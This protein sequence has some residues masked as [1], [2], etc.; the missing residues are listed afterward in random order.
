MNIPH[1]LEPLVTEF[2]SRLSKDFGDPNIMTGDDGSCGLYWHRLNDERELVFELYVDFR[3]CGTKVKLYTFDRYRI[4][5]GEVYL[6]IPAVIPMIQAL[7]PD[8]RWDTDLTEVQVMSIEQA[9]HKVETE[10]RRQIL[11]NGVVAIPTTD[12]GRVGADPDAFSYSLDAPDP[13]EDE[14]K[15][16][17]KFGFPQDRR[18]FQNKLQARFKMKGRKR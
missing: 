5:T 2:L 15:N 9:R 16:A 6:E 4:W 11:D 7:Y 3:A 13:A 18:Q 10:L 8:Y 1:A 14:R 17:F 12:I